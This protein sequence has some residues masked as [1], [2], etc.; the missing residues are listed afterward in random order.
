MVVA[1]LHII[2]EPLSSLLRFLANTSPRAP[3]DAI[4]SLFL[5]C[6]FVKSSILRGEG[7][8]KW[9][10]VCHVDWCRRISSCSE[11][12]RLSDTVST[13]NASYL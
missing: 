9:R 6:I 5:D 12:V 3:L 2:Y 13:L 8:N 10:S 4:P 11:A 7:P 1:P